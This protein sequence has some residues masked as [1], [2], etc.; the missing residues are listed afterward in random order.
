MDQSLA[1]SKSRRSSR[2]RRVRPLANDQTEPLELAVRRLA[3]SCD[4]AAARDG[5]GFNRLD[6][7]FGHKLAGMPFGE[8]TPRQ[9]RAAWRMLAKYGAQLRLS[10][11]DY[12]S[13]PEPPDAPTEQVKKQITLS[14]DGQYFVIAF[15]YDPDLV[16]E[17]RQIPGRSFHGAT[18]AW[19]APATPLAVG[20]V[21]EFGAAHDFAFSD[22]AL[23]TCHAGAE[24][25][26]SN[27]AASR[28]TSA[29][30]D[31]DG[32]GGELRPFQRAGV[33]YA[34]QNKR[35]FLADEMGLGKTVQA[36]A[37]LHGVS[38][39]PAV[40]VC[41]SSL[42]L[43]WQ[44]EA[45]IWLPGRRVEVLSGL[46]NGTRRVLV[47]RLRQADVIVINYDILNS[48]LDALKDLHPQAVVFDESHYLKGH[49]AKRTR[50]A[51]QLV[52][53]VEIRLM[54]T[55]TPFL[56][57][58]SEG[59]APLRILGRL[60][61]LGGWTCYAT[62]YC[63]GYHDG[64]AWNLSGH[65]HLDELNE[66]LRATCYIRRTKQEVLSE[67]PPKVRSLVPIELTPHAQ[68]E[69]DRASRDTVGYLAD[70]AERDATFLRS[71]AGPS[72]KAQQAARR[73]RR[74]D[75]A[76][77]AR[78]AEILV[79][80]NTL[81]R[82]VARG[83]LEA[84]REWVGTFL[85]SEEKLVVFAWHREIVSS[86]AKAFDSPHIH[87]KT[88]SKKRQ[89]VVEQFQGDPECRL[90]VMNMQA[91][92]LGLTLTAA[93][94]VAICELPWTPGVLDQAEARCHRM[95]QRSSVTAWYLLCQ[96]SI[97]ADIY[98]LINR[99]RAVVDAATEGQAGEHDIHVV[100]AIV[101]RMLSRTTRTG[102][103]N[104][105]TRRSQRSI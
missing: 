35:I 37:T 99:K 87:G 49:K 20:P 31:L 1:S 63:D 103:T 74:E 64:F 2:T 69:Y 61:D 104:P 59:I 51:E 5:A 10:G 4:G 52:T 92:G 77:R 62:R 85:E 19:T 45:N 76:C 102:E 13:I 33:A 80:L 41:P 7:S 84:I 73:E 47:T 86:L 48:W 17:V 29:Q 71:L 39:F 68:S 24:T 9:R 34:M 38:S 42:K 3:V 78:Q 53:N 55:G 75:A 93:S 79:R 44:R 101:E 43:N 95:G 15:P 58:P 25:V 40:V 21:W 8:W 100:K 97:E 60:D 32:I 6:A 98:E 28:A 23:A 16:Q 50:A 18:K 14:A 57:R 81:K 72:Q 105:P 65:A 94:N 66:R 26:A 88:P 82:I 12:P 36:L 90:L 89:A 54:L 11:I 91:G 30:L 83:K 46:A 67:L 22:Q 27:I 56:N 96:Q 70:L